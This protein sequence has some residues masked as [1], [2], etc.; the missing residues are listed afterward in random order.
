MSTRKGGE[1]EGN[2]KG[3]ALTERIRPMRLLRVEVEV[4][5]VRSAGR[6]RGLESSLDMDSA[7]MSGPEVAIERFTVVNSIELE[8]AANSFLLYHSSEVTA[9]VAIQSAVHMPYVGFAPSTCSRHDSSYCDNL[10]S[11]DD[12]VAPCG[13]G[14]LRKCSVQGSLIC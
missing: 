11:C 9:S 8:G 12:S 4:G 5:C 7:V 3:G 10:V 13:T 6:S 1:K 14:G 2:E